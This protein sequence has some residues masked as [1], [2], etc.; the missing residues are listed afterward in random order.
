MDVAAFAALPRI[1]KAKNAGQLQRHGFT[2]PFARKRAAIVTTAFRSLHHRLKG[3]E[4]EDESE[5]EDV[6][7][8][9]LARDTEEPESRPRSRMSTDEDHFGPWGP[10]DEDSMT[11]SSFAVNDALGPGKKR[12]LDLQVEATLKRQKKSDEELFGVSIDTIDPD[13]PVPR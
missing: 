9:S 4:S 6:N 13:F 7:R 8:D 1:R 3:L 2:D 10:A 11:E 12:K 5:D